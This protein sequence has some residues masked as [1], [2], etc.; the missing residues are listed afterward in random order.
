[1]NTVRKNTPVKPI[2][3]EDLASYSVGP[4]FPALENKMLV[5]CADKLDVF[6]LRGNHRHVIPDMETFYKMGLDLRDVVTI[7]E[8]DLED[9]PRGHPIRSVIK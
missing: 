2:S 8:L 4:P 9:I 5:K 1:M 6:I 3:R 7:S